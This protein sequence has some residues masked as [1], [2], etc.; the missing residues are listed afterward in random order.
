MR[1]RGGGAASLRAA[2]RQIRARAQPARAR[3]P[4]HQAPAGDRGPR[5]SAEGERTM[6]QEQERA[7]LAAVK[8]HFNHPDV[9]LRP[10]AGRWETEI[11]RCGHDRLH[12]EHMRGCI[13]CL[14]I[15]AEQNSV[16]PALGVLVPDW[17]WR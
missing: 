9:P 8:D 15:S 5:A 3:V 17:E 1:A 4:A 10:G 7:L 14:V 12:E 11:W 6:T 13:C 16:L 2:A